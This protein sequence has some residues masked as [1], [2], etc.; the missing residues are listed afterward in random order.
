MPKHYLATLLFI[1]FYIGVHA[2]LLEP[3]EGTTLNSVPQIPAPNTEVNFNNQTQ[4]LSTSNFS[5]VLIVGIADMNGDNLD[6]IIRLQDGKD[7]TIEY[8][9]CGT[10]F[11]SYS[12]GE[13]SLNQQWSLAIAD[14]DGNGYNDIMVGGIN[15]GIKLLLAD[16]SGLFYTE[17]ILPDSEFFVQGSNF[18]DINHDGLV[19]VFVCNDLGE[20][21]I[22]ENTGNAN[23]IPANDWV[24]MSTVPL[25]DNSG[26]YASAWTDFDNDGDL[27]LHISKCRVN[28][29]DV[30]DPRRVNQLFVN[31]GSN[32]FTE[33]AE[34]F[35]LK[36]GAQTWTSDFQDI[37]N[38]GDLDCFVVNHT[39]P[40]VDSI[41]SQ[42]LLNNGAGYYSDATETI[43][44]DIQ[45]N[46]LQGILRD[47]DN[48]GFVDILVAGNNGYQFFQNNGNLT[49]SEISGTFGNYLMGTFAVG[50][51]NHDG[52]LDLYSGS[53]VSNDVLWMNET[54][55]NNFL[56]VNL[57]A[58]SGEPNAI[59]TRLEIYGA[60]G[61]QIREVRA[62]ESYGIMNSYTQHF[63]LGSNNEIDSLIIRWPSGNVEVFQNPQI[64]QFLNIVENECAYPDRHISCDGD[65]VICTG[66]TILLTAPAGELFSWSTG[67]NTP[68]LEVVQGGL[69]QV[70]VTNAYGCSSIS[71]ILEVIQ[72]P[73]EN[74]VITPSGATTFCAGQN[75]LLFSS[76]EDNYLWSTG[77]QSQSI[78]VLQ[79]G[80]YTVTT[81]GLCQDFTSPPVV[82]EV[83]PVP[84]NPEVENDFIL[85]EDVPASGILTATGDNIF[86]FDMLSGGTLLDVGNTFVTPEVTETTSFY[87]QDITTVNNVSCVSQRVE[88]LVVVDSVNTTKEELG[89]LLFEVYPNP[90]SDFIILKIGKDHIEN[91][92][93]RIINAAGQ[94]MLIKKLENINEENYIEIDDLM[95]GIYILIVETGEDIYFEKV[96][97]NRE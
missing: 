5:S 23:F 33:M 89:E 69:Y 91:V 65:L 82:V 4:L 64:N 77:Q 22:W 14:I 20:S 27:D 83:I 9:A 3:S 1:F 57:K 48:D 12:F 37:D 58:T 74:P 95:D 43:G 97:I 76:V 88:G 78:L 36:N 92:I 24:D 45:N 29:T 40:N 11:Y 13:V 8:Q 67:A 49:F 53:A 72:D 70:T 41:Q 10:D 80:E 42:L 16:N 19:D 6:D 44:L 66:D 38:D 34:T 86:W 25:S 51:L 61:M 32:N 94:Q 7:L 2:Q 28:V 31:D 47:F 54:N 85:E 17:T 55:S 63:G 96:V 71:S 21:R 90:T 18:V 50:D 87:A 59:G 81:S 30:N 26:N 56:A 68:Q 15:D 60:W 75:V 84:S 79:S 35:G 62:G 93:I 39:K 52:F 46:H 73:I